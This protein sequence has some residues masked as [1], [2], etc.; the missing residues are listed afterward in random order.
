MAEL[1]LEQL[2]LELTAFHGINDSRALKAQLEKVLLPYFS[3]KEFCLINFEDSKASLE[4]RTIKYI[5]FD[6][7]ILKVGQVCST[8]NQ[9]LQHFYDNN[10]MIDSI[11][12]KDMEVDDIIID[13]SNKNYTN[14]EVPTA[15]LGVNSIYKVDF[16]NNMGCETVDH[17]W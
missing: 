11:D 6:E 1:N 2:Q 13:L 4:M 12:I 5:E 7:T 14:S 3:F 16:K 8:T 10:L 15:L 9:W 17:L